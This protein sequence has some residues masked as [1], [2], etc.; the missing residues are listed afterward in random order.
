[1]EFLGFLP[2]RRVAVATGRVGLPD[3]HKDVA[4]GL[5]QPVQNAA[6]DANALARRVLT[7]QYVAE[8]RFKYVKPGLLR[9]QSD[10]DV[11]PGGLGRGLGQIVDRGDHGINSRAA[12]F[13]TVW[14]ACRAARCRTDRPDCRSE[15]PT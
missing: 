11:R 7:G 8:R 4:A 6:L 14:T 9:D 15:S 13:R 1:I 12:C 3:L 5:G 2:V 10:V